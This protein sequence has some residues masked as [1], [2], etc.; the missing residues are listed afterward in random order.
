MSA[1]AS[2]LVSLAGAAAPAVEA[3]AI[4]WTEYV[5]DGLAAKLLPKL[6]AALQGAFAAA[7]EELKTNETLLG[8]TTAHGFT[9]LVAHLAMGDED[10]AR[11]VWLSTAAD[12]DAEMDAVD[13]AYLAN[14]KDST[15]KAGTWGTIKRIALAVLEAGGEVGARAIVPALLALIPLPL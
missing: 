11:L 12:F 4:R 1:T 2:V 7:I 13:A 15:S 5:A 8:E 10:A 3:T 9:A 14:R 6:P